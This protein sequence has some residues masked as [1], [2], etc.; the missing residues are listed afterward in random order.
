MSKEITVYGFPYLVCHRYCGDVIEVY[1]FIHR[2]YTSGHDLLP[3]ASRSALRGHE[4]KL[5]KDTVAHN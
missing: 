1:K 3:R 2:M 4:Y 5:K